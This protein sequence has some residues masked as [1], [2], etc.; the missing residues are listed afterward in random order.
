MASRLKSLE[1]FGYKTFANKTLFEFSDHVTSIIGPN[2]SGKSNIAD[3]L[4]WVLGEQSYRLLRGKKTE[5]MIFSGSELRPRLGM[6]SA[7]ITFDNSDGWLPIDF[8][9]VAIARRAYRDGTNEY[10]INGQRVRLKDVSE[11]LAESGLAERTYTIIGQGLVDAALSLKAEERRKLFE[12]AAGIG[13]YRSRREEALRRLDTTRR[14]I[15]RVE[16]ILS[17]L[18]PRLRSLERQ[19]RRAKDYDQVKNDLR[20]M[21]LEWYGYHWRLLQKKVA[22]EQGKT[23]EQQLL[24]SEAKKEQQALEHRSE[25]LY[26]RVKE[27]RIFI[28][29]NHRE[30]SRLHSEKE[31]INREYAVSNERIRSFKEQIERTQTELSKILEEREMQKAEIDTLK[32]EIVSQ[33]AELDEARNFLKVSKDKQSEQDQIRKSLEKELQNIQNELILTNSKLNQYKV[34]LVEKEDQLENTEKQIKRVGDLINS[35]QNQREEKEKELIDLNQKFN[36]LQ[37]NY[38]HQFEIIRKLEEKVN[39]NLNDLQRLNERLNNMM[40]RKSR[41]ISELDVLEQAENSLVGYK[42]GTKTVIK[43]FNKGEL[44]G[45]LGILIRNLEVEPD[46]DIAISAALGEYLDSILLEDD[47]DAALDVLKK[48]SKR[49]VLIP[50]NSLR[51]QKAINPPADGSEILGLATKFVKFSKRYKDVVELLLGDAVLVKDRKTAKRLIRENKWKD[52]RFITLSGEVFYAGGQI[53]Y[54]GVSNSDENQ[55]LFSRQRQIKKIKTSIEELE[56]E[57][58]GYL[59]KRKVLENEKDEFV[60]KKQQEDARIEQYKEKR[61]QFTVTLRKLEIDLEKTNQEYQWA[62]KEKNKLGSEFQKIEENIKEFKEKIR[63]SQEK[64]PE[65]ENNIK[66]KQNELY[67][68][69][70]DDLKAQVSHWEIDIAVLEKTLQTTNARLAERLANVEQLNQMEIILKQRIDEN[71]NS[72]SN[73]LDTIH[74]Q[75]EQEEKITQQINEIHDLLKPAEIELPELEKKHSV[76]QADLVKLRKKVN[77]EEQ[78]YSKARITLARVKERIL[79][80]QNQIESDFGLVDYP[81]AES[82]DGQTPLPLEG[83]VEQLPIVDEVA[84]ELESSIKRLKVQIRRMGAINP[85]AEREYKE[86]KERF[87][88]LTNQIED[89]NKAEEDIHVVIGELD[90]IMAKE[91]INTFRAVAAEFREIFKR[92]FGGGSADLILSDKDDVMNA[93]IEIDARL[94]GRRTQGLSLLSGGERSLSATALIFALLKVSPTPFCLLDEVDAMLDEANAA[95]FR[96]LLSE[97]SENTQFIIVT[98]NRNTVQAA[99]VIYGITMGRDSSSKVISLKVD[100][101]GEMVD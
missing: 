56:K 74:G 95:R 27:L 66:E 34:Y 26:K 100:E 12:E 28:T 20:E 62:E 73:L 98:H 25:E 80:L 40:A 77:K 42:E 86:V 19:A 82:V 79:T 10:L 89:L 3:S 33:G 2:G 71:K 101:V 58:A 94:P 91:F 99:D 53:Y 55:D 67:Q 43:A 47:P 75:S 35:L 38:N 65:L 8:S 83:F 30:L 23:D 21:L 7:T 61:E 18:K 32:R 11:L 78:S 59:Q 14:N 41:L 84:P 37:V 63:E 51:I 90:D 49:G 36:E 96:D 52:L 88:F 85:E 70:P 13:L 39:Q 92:L 45:V 16:D 50:I 31:N 72:L 1:L 44:G 15:E 24:L 81:Y 17:E 5:D 60:E 29:N 57:I 76:L 54:H 22:H 4:R 48:R 68:F 6:A 64:I 87:D 97:M 9:E 69:S 46:Y 93:G